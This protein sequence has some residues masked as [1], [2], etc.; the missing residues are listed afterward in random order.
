LESLRE[1]L[2]DN[3]AYKVSIF[4]TQ[5]APYINLQKILSDHN[6]PDDALVITERGRSRAFVELLAKRLKYRQP[7]LANINKLHIDE[8]KAIAKKQNATIVE[9]SVVLENYKFENR[10]QTRESELLI[11]VIKPTGEVALR[12]QN[13]ASLWQKQNIFVEDL[14]FSSR[15]QLSAR[16]LPMVGVRPRLGTQLR[17]KPNIPKSLQQLHQ[18]LIE[19]IAD[20]L[21]SDPNDHVI[22]RFVG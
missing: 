9:Y 20:L 19:P 7:E 1:R 6:Q 18:L 15:S 4:E 22:V 8:F 10:I 11:W 14:V 3:D 17:A 16:G 13:L 12:R 2:K 21:P 5:N